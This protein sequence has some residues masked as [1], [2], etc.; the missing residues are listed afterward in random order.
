MSEE[1]AGHDQAKEPIIRII[2]C[3]AGARCQIK[4]GRFEAAARFVHI[5]PRKSLRDTDETFGISLV[6]SGKESVILVGG[7]REQARCRACWGCDLNIL[8]E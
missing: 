5:W 8:H 2:R 1:F 3:C 4:V 6:I 7:S